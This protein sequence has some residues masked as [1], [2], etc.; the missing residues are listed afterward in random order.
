MQVANH[1]FRQIICC[2]F[3][4][5]AVDGE[6]PIVVCLVARD[7]VTGQTWRLWQEELE[8]LSG[9][10][11]PIGSDALFVAYYA[12]AEFGCFL[13]LGWPLPANTLDLFTEFRCLTNG[14]PVPSGNGL[15]GAL[16]YYG[17]DALSCTEK[18]TMRQ[19]V[20]RGGPWSQQEKSDLLDY[21]QSDVDA[22]VRLLPQMSSA[23]DMERAL[24]RGRYMQA[25]AGMESVGIPLDWEMLQ[26]LRLRWAAIK[27]ALVD[28][29]DAEY[30][31]YEGTTFK[32]ERFARWLVESDIPWPQL[33]SGQL[34]LKES[35]FKERANTY[36]ILQPIRELRVSLS[37][38]KLNDLAVGRDGRNRCLLSP[39]R[40]RTGRNQPSTSKFIFGNA[41]WVRSLIKP[42]EGYGVAYIDWSQQEFGIAAALSKDPLMM[43]AYASGDPYLAFAKQ[44]GAVPQDATKQSHKA[45]R[46]QYK[47]CVLAVQYGMGPESLATR[48]DQ[49]EISA[50]KL[51]RLHRETYRVFW[52]WSDAALD[53]AMLHSKLWTVFGWTIR[54]GEDPNDRSLRN[55]PMQANGAEMLRLAIIKTQ[56]AEIRVCAPVH[57]AILIEAPLDELDDAIVTTQQAMA[58]ASA[59]LL[60]GFRLRTDADVIRYPERYSDPRGTKMWQT[61]KELI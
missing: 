27:V 14:L 32:L 42:S 54:V 59:I 29:I 35:T 55:F 7:V 13:A 15:L 36:P 17:L 40:A 23:I 46:D 34:D 56:E 33:P 60:D 31:V 6:A 16:A 21:C 18:A 45:E 22:L 12:S 53:Y 50:R 58:D 10:P 43:D 20:L 1:E 19:L 3:E 28:R 37:Q 41:V 61:V 24:L 51:L 49:P 57:D 11:F 47:A 2:D 39:F 30:G 48:I 8:A 52:S 38:L 26:Q 25:V 5:V 4:F 9:P 44:A